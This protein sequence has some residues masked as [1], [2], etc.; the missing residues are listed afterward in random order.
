MEARDLVERLDWPAFARRMVVLARPEERQTARDLA[1][2]LPEESWIDRPHA[3]LARLVAGEP[4]HLADVVRCSLPWHGRDVAVP[5]VA[6]WLAEVAME[7]TFRVPR[8]TDVVSRIE[9]TTE[10]LGRGLLLLDDRLAMLPLLPYAR[11]VAVIQPG[12]TLKVS[13]GSLT[14]TTGTYERRD[15]KGVIVLDAQVLATTWAHELAHASDPRSGDGAL[16]AENF[17]V[18][19][20]DALLEHEPIDLRAA[21]PLIDAA[22]DHA[23]IQAPASADDR[24]ADVLLFLSAPLDIE[25]GAFTARAS[26][27]LHREGLPA[28]AAAASVNGGWSSPEGSPPAPTSQTATEGATA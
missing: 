10:P 13:I 26:G 19:L 9:E 27:T 23:G 11:S 15:D 28:R 8:R 1:D 24:F 3:H 21:R 22:R 5:V 20:G 7:I 12:G 17:A 25:S 16:A 2:T 18:Y 14:G 6:R 4:D